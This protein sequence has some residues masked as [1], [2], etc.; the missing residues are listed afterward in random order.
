MTD[1][2]LLEKIANDV[3][4]VKETVAR[5]E[6][7]QKA[8]GLIIGSIPRQIDDVETRMI[9]VVSSYAAQGQQLQAQAL[10]LIKAVTDIKKQVETARLNEESLQRQIDQIRESL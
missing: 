6:A 5:L 9:E 2:E 8:H 4:E 3:A 10:Q 7:T 1:R